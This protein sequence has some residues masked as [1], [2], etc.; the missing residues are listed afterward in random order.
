[1]CKEC[2]GCMYVGIK[3]L[4]Y[5]SF[6]DVPKDV[7]NKIFKSERITK[8]TK[9]G[10]VNCLNL[11]NERGDILL[12]SYVNNKIKL[13]IKR[14]KCGH[15][16]DVQISNY[17]RQGCGLC[18]GHSKE[19]GKANF[20]KKLKENKDELIGEYIDSKTHVTIKWHDCGHTTKITP[21]KYLTN[22]GC[23]ICW[24]EILKSGDIIRDKWENDEEFRQHMSKVIKDW[25]NTEEGNKQRDICRDKMKELNDIKWRMNYKGGITPISNYLR[26]L[27]I[28]VKWKEDAKKNV[29]YTCELIGKQCYVETHHIKPFCE[30]VM[31]AHVLND[32]Q[33][34]EIVA[35][36]T[37]EELKLLV[38]YI[39]KWHQDFSNA[40]VLSIEVHYY[41]HNVFM[42]GKGRESSVEDVEEFKE[43]YLNGEFSDL[44]GDDLNV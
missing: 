39:T 1:M 25:W 27:P 18:N 44:L 36:Y 8:Q 20:F 14:T 3:G 42:K 11:I 29:N 38:A 17:K 26:N 41:F 32:I 35:D 12:S 19:F 30:L 22:T 7:V 5:K 21:N 15:I 6:E 2:E 28:V 34:K 31:E 43:R 10:F 4:V 37:E 40:I 16:T 23:G 9:E 33:I 24:K 13:K